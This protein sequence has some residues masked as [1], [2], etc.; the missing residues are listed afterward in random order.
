MT[1]V[2]RR[3]RVRTCLAA[4]SALC[5]G[6][7]LASCAAGPGAGQVPGTESDPSAEAGTGS[8]NSV[9]LALSGSDPRVIRSDAPLGG[10]S[11][12]ALLT[13]RLGIGRGNCLGVATD[14][15][16]AVPAFPATAQLLAGG[17]PGIDIEG[18]RYL[19]GEEVSFGG[20][21]AVLDD[22]RKRAL[23]PCLGEGDSDIFLIGS[24]GP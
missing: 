16:L 2:P 22:E 9:E 5:M 17:R 13:G 24:L 19:V 4:A 21:L 15:G 1:T 20:G 14:K 11:A 18:H 6:L 12:K 3:L 23:A 8:L 7:L 10:S